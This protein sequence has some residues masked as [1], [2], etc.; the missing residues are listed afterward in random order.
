MFE[1]DKINIL[2]NI[3]L[4]YIYIYIYIGFTVNLSKDVTAIY[5]NDTLKLVS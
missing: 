5:E 2:Y 4:I 1:S 3:N